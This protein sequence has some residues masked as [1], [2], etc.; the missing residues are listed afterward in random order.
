MLKHT[1]YKLKETEETNKEK[2][3]REDLNKEN[4]KIPT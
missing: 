3:T 1:T 2:Q 4:E